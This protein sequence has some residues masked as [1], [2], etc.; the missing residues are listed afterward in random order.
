MEEIG[1]GARI[2]QAADELPSAHSSQSSPE[3]ATAVLGRN[4]SRAPRAAE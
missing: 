1:A 4:Q 2:G 3:A